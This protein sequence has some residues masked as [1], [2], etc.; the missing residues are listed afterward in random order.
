MLCIDRQ[1]RSEP[2]E[3]AKSMTAIKVEYFTSTCMDPTPITTFFL[4]IIIISSSIL[5]HALQQI[6]YNEPSSIDC[7][8]Q[9]FFLDTSEIR[10]WRLESRTL[11]IRISVHNHLSYKFH[12]N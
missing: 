9:L 5:R 7:E 1:I 2:V 11:N 4:K 8:K 6:F 10:D 3:S 12:I